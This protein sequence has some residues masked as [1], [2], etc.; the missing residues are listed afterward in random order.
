MVDMP[1]NP[2]VLPLI[3]PFLDNAL[4]EA[5]LVRLTRHYAN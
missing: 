3:T 5:S 2:R 4:D 1:P